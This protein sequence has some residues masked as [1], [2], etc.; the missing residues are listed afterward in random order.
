MF[1]TADPAKDDKLLTKAELEL[2]LLE[3]TDDDPGPGDG[4]DILVAFYSLFII[5]YFTQ[6]SFDDVSLNP[7]AGLAVSVTQEE[8][9]SRGLV[10]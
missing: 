3:G 6:L 1:V 9:Y 8:S 10:D 4:E 5:P 2:T 7:E